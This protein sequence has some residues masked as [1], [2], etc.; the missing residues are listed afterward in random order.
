M[1]QE[2]YAFVLHVFL[3]CFFWCMWHVYNAGSLEKV[4][5]F[6][7]Q[8]R[9]YTAVNIRNLTADVQLQKYCVTPWQ[10]SRYNTGFTL[11]RI[12]EIWSTLSGDRQICPLTAK[13]P[14]SLH[15]RQHIGWNASKKLLY[16]LSISA[17]CWWEREG[18]HWEHTSVSAQHCWR[19]RP[20]CLLPISPCH[21]I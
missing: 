18:V 17:F 3:C 5:N 14:P 2:N 19:V 9:I 7:L 12:L 20:D 8:C 4:L 1:D 13:P 6:E 10:T 16:I 15:L 21:E 11:Q